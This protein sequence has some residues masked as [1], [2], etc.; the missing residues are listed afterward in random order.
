MSL[1]SEHIEK[2]PEDAKRLIG[3][4]YEFLQQLIEKAEAESKKYRTEKITLIAKG[5]GRKP[6]LSNQDQILLTLSY[7]RHHSTFQYLGLNFVFVSQ[8]P[9]IFFIT[10]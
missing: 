5:G 7:L 2:K 8:L 3:I 1:L 4:D 10:G 6:S 9:I